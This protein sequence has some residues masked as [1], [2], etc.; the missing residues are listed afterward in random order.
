MLAGLTRVFLGGRVGSGRQYISWIHI[1]DLLAMFIRA[2][3][4]DTI[5]GLYNATG[6]Q[7][8]TNDQFMRSLRRAL[9]RPWSP[10]T[11]A[12]A[13]HVGSFF[14]RTEPVLALTGRRV[15]P[16]RWIQAGFNFRFSQLDA[17]LNNLFQP[18]AGEMIEA[19]RPVMPCSRRWE[20]NSSASCAVW[21]LRPAL[22]YC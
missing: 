9:H 15:S 5:A 19:I 1:D 22:G 17:A 6:P 16:W 18:P 2:I 10:P 13:V 21:L 7:P 20:K 12:W 14:L 8:V 3:E 4:D 11:P